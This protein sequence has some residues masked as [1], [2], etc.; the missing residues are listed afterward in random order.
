MSKQNLK[1]E[2]KSEHKIMSEHE[3][4]F[5]KAVDDGKIGRI[6]AVTIT[7]GKWI[8][9]SIIRWETSELRV[10]YNKSRGMLLVIYKKKM[11]VFAGMS[12]VAPYFIDSNWWK[13]IDD[14]YQHII[15]ISIRAK[16]YNCLHISEN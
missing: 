13:I 8:S 11:V 5:F 4:E 16:L 14:V 2:P 3:L 7:L 9:K 1:P 15:P 12:T 6:I 10:T